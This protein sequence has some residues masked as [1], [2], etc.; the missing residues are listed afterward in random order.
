MEV[1]KA[2]VSRLHLSKSHGAVV[3]HT[4]TMFRF[5]IKEP[6]DRSMD[7]IK[8]VSENTITYVWHTLG[9]FTSWMP[10]N[11]SVVFCFDLPPSLK[12]SLFVSFRDSTTPIRMDDPFAVHVVLL[13]EVISL[14]D[15]VLW[16]TRDLVRGIE[17]VATAV[18]GRRRM[19]TKLKTRTGLFDTYLKTDLQTVFHRP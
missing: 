13:E 4:G 19:G 8:D 17:K 3:D 2:I 5:L 10:L 6:R 16:S 11:G 1:C 14:F 15:H 9:F 18:V 7:P 12:D